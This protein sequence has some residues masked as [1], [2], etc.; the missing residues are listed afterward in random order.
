MAAI[1][2]GRDKI[3]PAGRGRRERPE[4]EFEIVASSDQVVELRA[5]GLEAPVF[6][7]VVEGRIRK[8]DERGLVGS[9]WGVVQSSMARE[10]RGEELVPRAHFFP[11][12]EL[13]LPAQVRELVD[14]FLVVIEEYAA[15]GIVGDGELGAGPVEI[16]IH[17]VMGRRREL[18][19]SEAGFVEPV[20]VKVDGLGSGRI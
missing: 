7:D 9:S 11:S 16:Q 10:D 14:V 12:R 4:L 17:G 8:E 6:A 19:L 13:M 1:A 3:L 15:R 18:Q 5:V 20:V 2:R